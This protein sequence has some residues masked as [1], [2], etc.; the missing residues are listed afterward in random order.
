MDLD[1]LDKTYPMVKSKLSFENFDQN[2]LIGW[3]HLLDRPTSLV[4]AN[5]GCHFSCVFLQEFCTPSVD[6][7]L[8][9]L[10]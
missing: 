6:F 1:V 4:F 10:N 5:F 9:L 3:A 2:G 8:N 7:N